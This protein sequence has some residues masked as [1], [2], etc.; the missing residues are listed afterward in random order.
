MKNTL[1]DLKTTELLKEKKSLFP[2]EE[3]FIILCKLFLEASD[4]PV[5]MLAQDE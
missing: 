2:T 3:A 5:L 1:V 4:R